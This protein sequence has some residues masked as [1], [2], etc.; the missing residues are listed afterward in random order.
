[1]FETHSQGNEA[2]M[3]LSGEMVA[4]LI[5]DLRD[6]IQALFPNHNRIILNFAK[7]EIIDSTMVGLLISSQNLFKAHGGRLILKD[8][9]EDV[10]RM[11]R[12]M[13]LDRHFE[14]VPRG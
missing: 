7:V 6:Q 8:V 1:M 10:I 14:I 11:L 9:S 12:I 2:T 3:E 13:R 4:G 5:G